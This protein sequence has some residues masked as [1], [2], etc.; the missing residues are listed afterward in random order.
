[1]INKIKYIYMR[2]RT[3]LELKAQAKKYGLRGHYKWSKE[4]LWEKI[5]I[6]EK[7]EWSIAEL[8]SK[9]YSKT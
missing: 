1:V 8:K 5:L 9:T 2:Y 3:L 6:I 7:A 4:K